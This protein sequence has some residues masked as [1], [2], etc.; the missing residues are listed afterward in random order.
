MLVLPHSQIRMGVNYF[1]LF[2]KQ[3]KQRC[4]QKREDKI[5]ESLEEP[6]CSVTL[7]PISVLTAS[8]GNSAG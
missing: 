1:E 7:R 3:M 5:L 4:R 6:P 8:F 2:F